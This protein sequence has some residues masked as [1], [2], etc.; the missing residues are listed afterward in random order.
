LEHQN[1]STTRTS[2]RVIPHD[3]E[4]AE[5]IKE[6]AI[7][8]M[9]LQRK[10]K[11]LKNT[12]TSIFVGEGGAGGARKLLVDFCSSQEFLEPNPAKSKGWVHF[13]AVIVWQ[14]V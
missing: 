6:A 8:T 11:H 4:G 12:E 10:D 9:F 7:V 14:L 5:G 2:L 1:C 13:E 3:V